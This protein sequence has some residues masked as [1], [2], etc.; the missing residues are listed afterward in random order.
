[1]C[2]IHNLHERLSIIFI[3]S[4]NLLVFPL[5]PRFLSS[6]S[7]FLLPFPPLCWLLPQFLSSPSQK[8]HSRMPWA[9]RLKKVCEVTGIQNARTPTSAGK[10]ITFVCSGNQAGRQAGR[11][12]DAGRTPS[13]HLFSFAVS[14]SHSSLSLPLSTETVALRHHPLPSGSNQ[15]S[16]A[17][18]RGCPPSTTLPLL[19]VLFFFLGASVSHNHP[20]T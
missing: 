10:G 20:K 5:P 15:W 18:T 14:F 11:H 17:K 7:D 16:T 13:V 1:M 19:P 2:C 9:V 12:T 4:I 8:D 6:S 3:Q